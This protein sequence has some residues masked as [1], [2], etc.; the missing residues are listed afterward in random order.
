MSEYTSH[1]KL[2]PKEFKKIGNPHLKKKEENSIAVD[3][4]FSIEKLLVI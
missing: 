4:E 1:I 3:N 2:D